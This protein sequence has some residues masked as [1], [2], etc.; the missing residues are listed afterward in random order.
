MCDL[1]FLN[2]VFLLFRIVRW[3]SWKGVYFI[4]GEFVVIFESIVKIYLEVKEVYGVYGFVFVILVE[5]EIKVKVRIIWVVKIDV[6]VGF[7]GLKED[8]KCLL[9][10]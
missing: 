3:D 7:C 2:F 8:Y 4:V 9:D 5:D 10:F 1:C 6:L